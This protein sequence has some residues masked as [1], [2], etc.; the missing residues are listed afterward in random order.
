MSKLKIYG[1]S[2]SRASRVMWAARE[3]G[4]DF[5][6]IEVNPRDGG[7]KTASFL[8]IN[9]NGRVPAIEDG[10]VKLFESVAINLYLAKKHGSAGAAPLYPTAIEDEGRT[11]Q[12]SIWAINELEGLLM[13][14]LV[15]RVFKPEPDRNA[16]AAAEAEER[17]KRPLKVLDE[18]LAGRPWLLGDHFTIADLNVGSS[19]GS[20]GMAGVDLSG[21]AHVAEWLGRCTSRPAAQ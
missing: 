18:Q 10:D 21:F 1:T 20:A 6:L 19:L 7:N 17:L 4:I 13:T 5:D 9:P 8:A 16:A 3:L 12:W 11:F 2:R 14:C 15:E